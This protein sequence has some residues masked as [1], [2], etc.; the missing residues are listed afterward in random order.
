MVES[1]F[2][3]A[4]DLYTATKPGVKCCRTCKHMSF[5]FGFGTWLCNKIPTATEEHE[6]SPHT[7]VCL[8]WLKTDKVP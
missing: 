3:P 5:A 2:Y 8:W 7:Q 1:N 4:C 6:E